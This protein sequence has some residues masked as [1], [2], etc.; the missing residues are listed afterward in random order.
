[1]TKNMRSLSLRCE[2]EKMLWRGRPSGAVSRVS[3]SS[4]SPV[5]QAP[6]E[7]EAMMLLR[8]IASSKR[9]L[10]G[11]KVSTSKTPSLRDGRVLDR[12]D[13][14]GQVQI[15]ALLPGMLEDVGE[16]DV[17][18]AA[19]GVGVHAQPGRAGRSRCRGSLSRRLLRCRPS[20]ERGAAREA[21]DADRACPRPSRACRW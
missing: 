8:A 3:G 21:E 6:K 17:L 13:Q 16:Q 2:I 19:H 11:K 4:A 20:S 15:A 9:S 1:M 18:A 12:H 7:G 5:S 14:L 10:A